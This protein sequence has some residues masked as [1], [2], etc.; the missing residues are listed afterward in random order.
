MSWETAVAI[1]QLLGDAVTSNIVL[2]ATAVLIGAVGLGWLLAPDMMGDFWR[3]SPGDSLNYMGHRYGALLLGL[4]SGAL[5]AR[6]APNTQ[7]RRAL[8]TGA[9]VALAISTALSVY[10][11]LALAL[12]AWPAVIIESI[13]LAGFVWVLFIKPE[14][15]V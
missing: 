5:L 10:G 2:T 1:A 13:L 7:A 11:A 15:V 3:I 9:F 4:A 14:P 8:M 12:N 6:D